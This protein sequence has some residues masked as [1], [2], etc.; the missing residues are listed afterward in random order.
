SPRL[1]PRPSRQS[2]P[3]STL[4]NAIPCPGSF[5]FRAQSS[6]KA[7]PES[8]DDEL[9]KLEDRLRPFGFRARYG[10]VDGACKLAPPRIP[11][12]RRRLVEMLDL[13]LDGLERV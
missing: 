4:A 1:P 11:P 3:Q 13:T 9:V 12:C 2:T 10:V 8:F 5:P 6:S 7:Y